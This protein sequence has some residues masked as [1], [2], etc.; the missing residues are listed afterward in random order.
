MT[1]TVHLLIQL[2]IN[3]DAL[4]HKIKMAADDGSRT[5]AP[6]YPIIPDISIPYRNLI[7]WLGVLGLSGFVWSVQDWSDL[8]GFCAHFYT[9]EIIEISRKQ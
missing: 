8:F 9:Q 2:P 4:L 1:M 7:D 3:P 5:P 6:S